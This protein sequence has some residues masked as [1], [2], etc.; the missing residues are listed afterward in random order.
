MNKIVTFFRNW[1]EKNNVIKL[2]I[3]FLLMFLFL[4]LGEKF[5]SVDIFTWIGLIATANI[6]L[7]GV[8]FIIAG[9][10]N[11]INDWIKKPK[12]TE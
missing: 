4:W 6:I 1:F 7:F 10:V 5:P 9:I 3:S 8:V 2:A 12:K 11:A